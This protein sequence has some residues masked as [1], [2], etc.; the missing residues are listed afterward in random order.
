MQH[1]R[2]A[3]RIVVLVLAATL[4]TL[5]W[6]GMPGTDLWV[7]SLARTPGAH[8]SQWYASVWIHNPGTVSAQVQ[9]SYLVRN[10][11]NPSPETQIV[12]VDPGETLKLGDV[13]QEVFGLDRAIGALRFESSAKIVVSARSYN[14]TSGGVAESQ[15]QFLAG[16]PSAIALSAGQRTSIPGITQPADG[17]FRCNYALVETGGGT[18]Q[19]E[20]SLYD[21]DGV[22]Q[23]SKIY[24]L[25]P[26]EPLQFNL[27]DLGAGL[28]VDGGRLDVEVLSGSGGVLTFASMVGNGTVSQDPSTLEMEY[29]LKQGSGSGIDSVEHDA[30]L[31]GDGTQASP[32][33]LAD[34]AVDTAKL[35]DS[36]VSNEK[37]STAGS[38]SGQV[39]MNQDGEVIWKDPPSGQGSGDITAVKAGAGLAGGGTSG[40]VTLRVADGGIGSA[41]IADGSVAAA[42]LADGAVGKSKLAAHGGTS[43]QVLGTDGSTL[44]W[45]DA[46]AGGSGDITAVNA[47]T[48][49]SGGGTSGDV[50]LSIANGG[51]DSTQLRG[52]AVTSDKIADGQVK[53]QDLATGAVDG[54]AI[55]PS[56]VTSDKIADGSVAKADLAAGAVDKS[57]L[58]AHGGSSG[59]VLGTDGSALVWQ[60]APA[61]GTGDIT[62]VAAGE[63]LAGGGDEGDVSL[64]LAD[65]G[66]TA[67][68]IRGN[69]VTSAKIADGQVRTQDLAFGA[70]SS[71]AIHDGAVRSADL[72]A[73]AV[74]TAKIA[75]NTIAAA[76]LADGAVVKTKLAASGGTSGQVLATDGHGG[77]LWQDAAAGAGDITA[78][79]AGDGLS[80]GG[81]S[82]D[83]TLDIANGG[84]DNVKIRGNAVTSD[85]IA[86]GQVG[87]NDLANNAVTSAKILSN[88]VTSA[89]IADGQVNTVDIANGSVLAEDLSSGAVTNDKLANGAVTKLKLS[90]AGGTSGQV[91]GTNGSALVWQDAASGSGDITAVTAGA[92]LG[93]G[94]TSGDVSLFIANGGVA[95]AMLAAAAVTKGKL[96]AAGGS[97]GQVLGTDG[98][99]LVWQDAGGGS[100]DITAVL[101]G[102][103]LTGGGTS[104]DVTLA[105]A[106]PVSINDNSVLGLVSATN[107]GGPGLVGETTLA[108]SAGAAGVAGF[109][110]PT[111]TQGIGVLGIAQSTTD[112]DTSHGVHGESHAIESTGV[113][114]VC[115]AVANCSGVRGILN[116]IDFDQWGGKQELVAGVTGVSHSANGIYGESTWWAAIQGKGAPGIWGRG[117]V[118]DPAGHSP[119][120][121]I[122]VL[123]EGTVAGV[124]GTSTGGI[125]VQGIAETD[126]NVTYGIWGEATDQNDFGILAKN[127]DGIALA[128]E[129]WGVG[130]DYPAASVLAHTAGGYG[131]VV[132]AQ[133][134]TGRIVSFR[135]SG[136]SRFYMKVNGSTHMAGTGSGASDATLYVDNSNAAGIAIN[137]SNNSTDATAVFGN[138]GTGDLLKLFHG[139]NLRFRV[140][141]DGEVSADGSFHSGGADF[142]ELIPVREEGLNPGDVVA[143]DVNG[144]LVRTTMAYQGSV[145]GVVSTKPGYQSDLFENVPGA[146][147]VPLAIVGIVPVRATAAGGPIRPGDMLTSSDVPGTAMRAR[148]PRIGTIIGKAMQGLESGEG[149]VLLLVSPR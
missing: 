96:A 23:A 81:T 31:T 14:L 125:G 147:K 103:H 138:E 86:D 136:T 98:A 41:K 70:V 29:E 122:G 36:S 88:A 105:L 99:G 113:Y 140:D 109:A 64:S 38:S 145:V 100:G 20:L 102:N 47:G 48:G 82:G 92:G 89:A 95:N 27:R 126:P 141:T 39:L 5:A 44:V 63:G 37:I 114:G 53:S 69:A 61:G 78:V 90:A 54:P 132:D 22:E 50:T 19:V 34:A 111:T 94:G 51:V 40:D 143:L 10:R 67:A 7:P 21:R 26:Y 13:F 1:T 120:T 46:G 56:A 68:K 127:Q 91:L 80:G 139:S 2:S 137:G 25:S 101:A 65:G 115:D 123:G 55:R 73:D 49:L 52:N 106:V 30:T 33:A 76:D 118:G 83:V 24:T 43:G 107:A 15:G 57:K 9:I 62:A 134:A 79:T 71:D 108:G 135:H 144:R 133:G 11:A 124:K 59:Q 77:L 130:S 66:V 117:T 3:H 142:A 4:A 58:S 129:G 35:A 148:R 72:A 93:G 131:L 6:A 116:N 128:V 110:D 146:D 97:A 8:G 75:N 32:L 85:K 149:T 12:T 119:G 121:N 45:Q 74:T 60:D 84:V 18:P 87:T 28:S 42:D 17:S 16:M 112:G 104:G